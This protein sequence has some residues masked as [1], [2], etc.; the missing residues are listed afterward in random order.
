MEGLAVVEGLGHARAPGVDLEVAGL[1][2]QHDGPRAQPR[3]AQPPRHA[4][5]LPVDDGRE[6]L[7]APQIVLEGV[8]RAQALGL[9]LGLHGAHVVT[10][11]QRREVGARGPQAR[12]QRR[13][14]TRHHVA[15][16]PQPRGVQHGL[17]LGPHA[18]QAPHRQRREERR[19]VGPRHV[20]L[21]VGLGQIRGDLGHELHGCDPGRGRQADLV[22]DPG[23]DP[24]RDV[25]AASEQGPRGAHVQEGLVQRQPLHQGRV[26]AE[27][28]EHPL[29]GL[30]VGGEARRESP[31]PRA[32]G[33][34]PRPSTS[35]C[36]PR[37]G[38]PRRRLR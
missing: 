22:A 3:R 32:P 1:Q 34:A 25:G 6:G 11:R 33:A 26:G 23:A 24:A 37:T 13:L 5:G 10:P 17:R 27:D 30:G 18:P 4:Q 21:A 9:A 2:L 28:L 16:R 7:D 36:A 31:A 20:E 29:A 35:R 8:L 14:P 12:H 19:G 15:Q 38:A